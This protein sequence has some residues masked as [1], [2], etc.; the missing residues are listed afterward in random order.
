MTQSLW[1]FISEIQPYYS[2]SSPSVTFQ[3]FLSCI[4]S[5]GILA[6]GFLQLSCDSP[7]FCTCL[8]NLGASG[9]PGALVSLICIRRVVKFYGLHIGF[10]TCCQDKIGI[11]KL[12]KCQIGNQ[13]STY[14]FQCT[15]MSE[16]PIL[17]LINIFVIFNY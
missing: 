8:F 16:L 2:S 4:Y 17:L 5:C 6:Y 15:N 1:D 14:F 12:L 9:L 3:V 10:L 7:Y 13:K 11:S